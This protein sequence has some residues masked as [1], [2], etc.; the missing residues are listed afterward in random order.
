MAPVKT[1][2]GWHKPALRMSNLALL[3]AVLSA[4]VTVPLAVFAWLMP[5][6]VVMSCFALLSVAFA[7]ALAVADRFAGPQRRADQPT[8]RDIAGAFALAAATA[9]VLA[10]IDDTARW[11][12]L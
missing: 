12:G 6:T 7:A 2:P 9:S 11:L 8:L 4:V 10:D 1:A 3:L 5:P